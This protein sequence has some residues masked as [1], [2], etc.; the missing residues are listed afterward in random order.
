VQELILHIE[1]LLSVRDCVIIP[2]F[3]A[4]IA[5]RR[6]AYIDE[7]SWEVIPPMREIC[8][9]ASITN[10]DGLLASSISRRNKISYE[11][12]VIEMNRMRDMLRGSLEADGE[13]SIGNVGVLTTDSG[14]TSFTPYRSPQAAAMRLGLNIVRL[15]SAPAEK[16]VRLS[17]QNDMPKSQ[18]YHLRISRRAVRVAAMIA[19]VILSGLSL[20]LPYSSVP[21][22]VPAKASVIPVEIPVKKSRFKEAGKKAIPADTVKKTSDTVGTA[23]EKKYHLIVAT[24]HSQRDADTFIAQNDAA[25]KLQILKNKKVYRISVAS[26]D[27]REELLPQLRSREITSRY[28]GCW[29]WPVK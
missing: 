3:G 5:F 28:P 16:T 23:K 29:I 4:F 1:Y 2:G 21:E 12:A 15:P 20:I 7:E 19:I 24:F 8:F 26:A 9:N 11:A 17:I 27:S 18:Y 14:R 22:R 25:G 13:V 10:N 6:D